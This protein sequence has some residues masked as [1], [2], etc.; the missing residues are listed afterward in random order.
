MTRP[1]ET[2]PEDGGASWSDERL[3][4]HLDVQSSLRPHAGELWIEES[5]RG[6]A[7]R[8]RGRG[9]VDLSPHEGLVR[10]KGAS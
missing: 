1:R 3:L 5:A 2:A 4:K 8:R 9:E 7:V 10:L 6:S